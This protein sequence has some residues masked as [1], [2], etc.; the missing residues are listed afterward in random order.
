M[1]PL[2]ERVLSSLQLW[3]KLSGPNQLMS[4]QQFVTEVQDQI[5]PLLSQDHLRTLALQLHSMGEVRGGGG[6]CAESWLDL[7]NLCRVSS[8]QPGPE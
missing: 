1:T 5:N 4:W 2:A 8:D 7:L 3:R 6:L